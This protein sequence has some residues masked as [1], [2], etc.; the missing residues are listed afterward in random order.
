MQSAKTHITQ[1][2]QDYI[3]LY[4]KDFETVK[5]GIKMQKNL[6]LDEFASAKLVGAPG[7]RGLFE[8]PV[9]LSEMLIMQLSEE[10]MEWFKAGG[11][12]RKEG[13]RWFARA[14]PFFALPDSI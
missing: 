9:E 8:I 6:H 7:M 14:F 3:R 13:G 11:A 12:N 2:V 1:I 4:P 5:E 10:E